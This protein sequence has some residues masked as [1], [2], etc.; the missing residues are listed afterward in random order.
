[1][2]RVLEQYAVGRVFGGGPRRPADESVDRVLRRDLVER[3]LVLGP[4]ELV[5]AVFDAVRPRREHLPASGRRQ[6][7]RGV[8]VEHVLV[9][10]RVG[11]EAGADLGD[12]DSLLA[13]E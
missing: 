8:A 1:M 5:G 13:G 7:V 2:Q 9:P 12:D 6:L 4:A 10:D 11:A 3:Q